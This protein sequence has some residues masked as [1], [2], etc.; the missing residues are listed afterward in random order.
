MILEMG[1]VAKSDM[2]KPPKVLM[3]RGRRRPQ[4]RRSGMTL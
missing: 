1:Y 3:E 4:R 2:N